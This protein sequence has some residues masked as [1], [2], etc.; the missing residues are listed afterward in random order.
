ML[1]PLYTDLNQQGVSLTKMLL[2]DMEPALDTIADIGIAIA[3]V[4]LVVV[5]FVY[6]TN[7]LDG[8]KFQVKMLVPIFVYLCVCNFKLVA[9]PVIWFTSTIQEK[10]VSAC[11]GIQDEFIRAHTSSDKAN[12]FSLFTAFMNESERRD[13]LSNT[14]KELGQQ[15]EASDDTGYAETEETVTHSKKGYFQALKDNLANSLKNF[16]DEVVVKRIWGGFIVAN[17]RSKTFGL[18]GLFVVILDFI[19]SIVALAITAMGAVMTAIVVCFGPITWAFAVYPN[20][21]KTLAAWAIRICQFSLYSPI[22]MLIQAFFT[23][24][25]YGLVDKLFTN[26]GAGSLLGIAGL[27]MGLIAALMSVPA[28]ASMII[29]GAQ[30]AVTLSQGIM[31]ITNIMQAGGSMAMRDVAQS[32]SSGG[33]SATPPPSAPPGGGPTP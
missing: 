32:S 30:G 17:L 13:P 29:E 28:I 23:T 27:I 20:N 9:G 3:S 5:I 4:F 22:C 10:C 15:D 11:K 24:M 8:G 26:G 31:T 21:S 1:Y 33:R 6:V 25:F 12:V 7:I 2:N 16:W 19:A 14:E 18:A